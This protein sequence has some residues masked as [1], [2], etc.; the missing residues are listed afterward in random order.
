MIKTKKVT[1]FAILILAIINSVIVVSHPQPEEII[2]YK[3]QASVDEIKFKVNKT[4]KIG[5]IDSGLFTSNKIVQKSMWKNNLETINGIDD[6][7]NGFID[8]INGWDFVEHDNNITDYSTDHGTNA[9]LIINDI[10]PNTINSIALEGDYIWCGTNGGVVRWDRS[11]GSY[12]VYNRGNGPVSNFVTSCA[13]D[14]NGI[15]WFSYGGHFPNPGKGVT[16]YD[17]VTWTNY[18]STNSGLSGDDIFCITVDRNNTKWFGSDDGRIS[19]FND[20]TWF[21]SPDSIAPI[22]NKVSAIAVDNENIK[23][24]FKGS[25][26]NINNRQEFNNYLSKI[27]N[28]VYAD[29]PVFQNEM[30]NKTKISATISFARKSLMERM[31]TNYSEFDFGYE[32]DKFPADKSRS[33]EH[34]SELQSH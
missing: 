10:N 2:D 20:E 7:N 13:V 1:I 29:T 16:K 23:W 34:T 19:W 32:T 25:E 14:S 4:V 9:L 12:V 24:F 5:L 18:T 21:T 28:D 22:T 31:L 27:C 30:V 11:D 6:D 26:T 33:E 3:H 8:D 15:K 17:G